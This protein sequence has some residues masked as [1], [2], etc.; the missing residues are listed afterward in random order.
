MI[1]QSS[2]WMR[3]PTFCYLGGQKH[4]FH[5]QPCFFGTDSF[6]KDLSDQSTPSYSFPMS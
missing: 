1:A 4:D 6:L 2:I 5:L 3:Q